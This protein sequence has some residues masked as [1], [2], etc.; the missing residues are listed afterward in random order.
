[1]ASEVVFAGGRQ[2]PALSL[3]TP[4]NDTILGNG[5]EADPLRTG[6]GVTNPFDQT[7]VLG[8]TALAN[9]PGQALCQ[10]VSAPN[11][12]IAAIANDATKVVLLGLM[13][14]LD[15]ND[16][17]VRSGGNLTLTTG[18]WDTVAGTSGGLAEGVPYYLSAATGGEITATPPV[19]TGDYA[20]LVGVALS[21]TTM[22]ILL[23]TPIGPHA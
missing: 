16:P 17:T 11:T 13:V 20:V 15:G 19:A 22:R 21:S 18:Q 2:V 1:M 23:G 4:D 3:V 14:S 7:F 9:H 6:P 12:P 10:S 8:S 5:T